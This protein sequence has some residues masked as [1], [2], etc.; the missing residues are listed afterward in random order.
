MMPD[1]RPRATHRDPFGIEQWLEAKRFQAQ[2]MEAVL[3][4]P[5]SLSI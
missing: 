2:A 1:L 4:E 3:D 5:L